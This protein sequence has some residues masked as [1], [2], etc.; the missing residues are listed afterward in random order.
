MHKRFAVGLFTLGL[1][2]VLASSPVA[3][4]TIIRVTQ[5]FLNGNRLTAASGT[6]VV[7]IPNTTQTLLGTTTICTTANWC[8]ATV[9]LTDAQ[10][11][12]L[13]TTPI[14]IVAAPGAGVIVDLFAA[15]ISSNTSAGAYTNINATSSLIWLD[16][17]GNPASGYVVTD[18]SVSV[19]DL[20]GLLGA[21]GRAI[22]KLPVPSLNAYDAGAVAGTWEWVT[23]TPNQPST[24][25]ENQ[26][27]TIRADNNGSGNYTGGN[28]AN[29]LRVTVRYGFETVQP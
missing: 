14:T 21:T 23:H 13:P 24:A 20:N 19:T 2:F 18:S 27:L 3:Q 17:N 9:T 25:M 26:P 12:A 6:A 29:R 15:V 16:V 7:T 11:K 4:G 22:N 28:T 5:L 8:Q 10:I 1:L